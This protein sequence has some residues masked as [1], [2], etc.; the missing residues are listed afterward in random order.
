MVF[1]TIRNDVENK[2]CDVDLTRSGNTLYWAQFGILSS[3]HTHVFRP[4]KFV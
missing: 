3:N 4:L 1:I 2:G